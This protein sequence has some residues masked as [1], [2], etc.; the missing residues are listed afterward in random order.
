M[1]NVYINN[2]KYFLDAVFVLNSKKYIIVDDGNVMSQDELQE[3]TNVE[4]YAL[5]GNI[6]FN[7]D[8][9]EK[10]N[11]VQSIINIVNTG[12]MMENDII[13]NLTFNDNFDNIVKMSVQTKDL[14]KMRR[15]INNN[16]FNGGIDA[17][18]QSN[19]SNELNSIGDGNDI[20]S[21]NIG[22]NSVDE[23]LKKIYE[24]MEEIKNHC[25]EIKKIV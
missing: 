23:H 11:L 4:F 25:D 12:V 21:Q 19:I 8:S 5:N 16:S 3:Y 15:L 9:S 18:F 20:V 13:S 10:N 14:D 24:L 17:D 6:L 7:V 22:A 1:Q 2:K